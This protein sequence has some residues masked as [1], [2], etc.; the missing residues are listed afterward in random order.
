MMSNTLSNYFLYDSNRFTYDEFRSA[1]KENIYS[2]TLLGRLYSLTINPNRSKIEKTIYIT[3]GILGYLFT[4]PF[5]ALYDL[6][7]CAFA[8][9][10]AGTTLEKN[11]RVKKEADFFYKNKDILL[12]GTLINTT[13]TSLLIAGALYLKK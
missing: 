13:I 9:I 5:S 8:V 10:R 7:A 6:S 1:C 12:A 3:L 11:A 4:T 2:Y